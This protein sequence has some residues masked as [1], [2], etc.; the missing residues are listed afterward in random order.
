MQKVLKVSIITKKRITHIIRPKED[1][2]PELFLL[3]FSKEVKTILG[4]L[5]KPTMV[6]LRLTC[7]VSP[8]NSESRITHTNYRTPSPTLTED[9]DIA[10][11]FE[12]D[13]DIRGGYFKW[14]KNE[15]DVVRVSELKLTG[16]TSAR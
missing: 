4:Y 7:D 6:T 11:I 5:P 1:Y 14:R 16:K 8:H 13:S 15:W 9:T 12:Y 10:T 2:D 3:I